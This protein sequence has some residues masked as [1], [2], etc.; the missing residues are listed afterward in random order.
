[1]DAHC[2]IQGVEVIECRDDRVAK[3][4]AEQIL[5]ARPAYSGIEVWKSGRRVH[6]QMSSDA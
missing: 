2:H 4:R 5:D 6:V 1:M 3:Q